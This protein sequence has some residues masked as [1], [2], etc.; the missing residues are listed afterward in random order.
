MATVDDW[1]DLV[2]VNYIAGY[3]GEFFSFLLYESF[4]GEIEYI[5]HEKKYRYDFS[6]LDPFGTT[7][8][9]KFNSLTHEIKTNYSN[10]YPIFYW[11]N[12]KQIDIDKIKN[13]YYV[14]DR[15]E[16]LL[17]LRYYF[18]DNYIPKY[19]QNNITNT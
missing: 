5:H 16:Y 10:T 9:Y 15:K 19:K 1:S 8:L 17:N 18:L 14:E 13:I 4:H 7:P 3:G 2:T 6:F 12:K 11:D